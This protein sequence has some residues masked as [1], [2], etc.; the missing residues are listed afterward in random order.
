MSRSCKA[1]NFR[2]SSDAFFPPLS[3]PSLSI[4][5]LF[6]SHTNKADLRK[7]GSTPCTEGNS[8]R[9]NIGDISQRGGVEDGKLLPLH[10]ISLNYK[11]YVSAEVF[12]AAMA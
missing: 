9:T 4:P 7:F 8:A 3:S 10:V 5:Y 2:L 6:F 11:D 12:I 1:V